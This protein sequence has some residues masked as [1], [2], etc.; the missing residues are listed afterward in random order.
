MRRG[1]DILAFQAHRELQD[2]RECRAGVSTADTVKWACRGCW[3]SPG[4]LAYPDP[5]VYLVSAKL[6][7][8]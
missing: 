5:P 2:R 1:V 6:L 8:A 7:L 4:A 3:D